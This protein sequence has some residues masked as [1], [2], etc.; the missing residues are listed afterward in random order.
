MFDELSH[1]NYFT[2]YAKNIIKTILELSLTTTLFVE[3]RPYLYKLRRTGEL[4]FIR[5][6]DDQREHICGQRRPWTY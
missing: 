2:L 5:E 4:F 1:V 6:G 3:G